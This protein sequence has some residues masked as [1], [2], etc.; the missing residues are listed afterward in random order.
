[1][2]DDLKVPKGEELFYKTVVEEIMNKV[3]ASIPEDQRPMMLMNTEI[4]FYNCFT[5]PVK[6][7]KN[8]MKSRKN[9]CLYFY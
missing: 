3:Y 7:A 4:N 8:P 6:C 9:A 2:L 1:M 5:R